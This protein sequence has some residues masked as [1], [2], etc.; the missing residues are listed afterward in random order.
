ML[1]TIADLVLL[2]LLF[3]VKMVQKE[4]GPMM[5]ATLEMMKE[6]IDNNNKVDDH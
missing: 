1:N 3:P 4:R 2:V 5:V 6:I